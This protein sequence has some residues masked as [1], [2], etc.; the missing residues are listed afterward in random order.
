MTLTRILLPVAALVLS[1]FLFG[2][3]NRIKAQF[4]GRRGRPLLQAYFDIAKLL[5]KGAVYG[6][7][8]GPVFRFAPAVVLAAAMLAV[9]LLP[10]GGIPAPVAFPG[11]FVLLA[12]LLGVTRFFTVLAALDTGSAFEGMGASR[13]VQ[14]AALGEPTLLLGMLLL[15]VQTGEL[16]TSSM[17]REIHIDTWQ[18]SPAAIVLL[19]IAWMV[20]LLTENSRI[21]VDDPN[22]HLELTMIHEVMVLD[23]GG[24]ELGLITLASSLKLFIFGGLLSNL[25]IPLRPSSPFIQAALFFVGVV[26]VAVVVGVVESVM[27]RLR[28]IQI[29][30]LLIGSTVLT[31]TALVMKLA[32]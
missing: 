26:A 3:I 28:L 27:G 8:T 24:P 12:Y 4:A 11:D 9:L 13:E 22:T 19:A 14:F 31:A 23:T 30:K 18:A 29:P 2:V 16:S 5:K 32:G 21:P 1:P 17:M 15:A 25:L 7:T 20:L 6:R 10:W